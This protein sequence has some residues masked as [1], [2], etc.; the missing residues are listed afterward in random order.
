MSSLFHKLFERHADP[1]KSSLQPRIPSRFEATHLR[2]ESNTIDHGLTPDN[3]VRSAE[4]TPVAQAQSSIPIE[5]VEHEQNAIQSPLANPTI[6]SD[7]SLDWQRRLIAAENALKILDGPASR[8]SLP[9]PPLAPYADVALPS[10]NSQPS[11]SVEAVHSHYHHYD[12]LP[13]PS[14][15]RSAPTPAVPSEATERKLPQNSALQF[16]PLETAPT[17]A[18]IVQINLDHLGDASKPTFRSPSEIVAPHKVA[19]TPIPPIEPTGTTRET[20]PKNS[21]ETVLDFEREYLTPNQP[22]AAWQSPRQETHPPR[23]YAEP[24]VSPKHQAAPPTIVIDAAPKQLEPS[25]T[26]H[27]SIGRILVRSSTPKTETIR[28]PAP[29]PASRVMTLEQYA[30]HRAGGNR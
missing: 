20:R 17:T 16:E 27:V 12:L 19:N 6:Y 13:E 14:L 7:V 22:E 28:Q 2:S 1:G 11:G 24:D 4:S 5:R 26:V 30:R 21:S 10:L 8:D 9:L 15:P 25:T 3:H 23:L 18:P 29:N